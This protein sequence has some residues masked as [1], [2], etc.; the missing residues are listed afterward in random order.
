M[1]GIA[2]IFA[3]AGAPIEP[4]MIQAMIATLGHRGPDEQGTWID[5][6]IGLASSRL[7]IIDLAGSHQPMHDKQAGGHLAFN[8]EIFNYREVRATTPYGYRTDGDTETL[9]AS[10]VQRGPVATVRE[11]VGQFAFGY[12]DSIGQSL[13]LAR[14][15]LGVLPLYYCQ[16]PGAVLFAS[17]IKAL[18]AARPTV[19][20]DQ[21]SITE[22]LVTRAVRAPHTLLAGIR[23]VSSAHLLTITADG[24]VSESRYWSPPQ[25]HDLWTDSS[26]TL[27]LDEALNKAVDRAL[28]ADVPVGSYLSGGLDSSLIATLASRRTQGQR[29][30]TFSAGF[31]GASKG[32]DELPYAEQVAASIGSEHHIVRIAPEAFEVEWSRLS[33]FRDGPLSEPADVAVAALA[34]LARQQVR[35][36]LSG[37]GADELFAGYPKHRFDALARFGQHVPE[38]WRQGLADT[39]ASR[40]PDSARRAQVMVRAAGASSELERFS[41]WFAPFTLAE[42]QQTYRMDDARIERV[43]DRQRTLFSDVPAQQ[44]TRLGRLLAYDLLTWL[45]DNLLERG[46]R[47]TMSASVELRPPFLDHELVELAFSLP[48]RYKLRGRTGKWLV[49]QVAARYLSPT[50]IN[51]RKAGFPVPLASWFR[52]DWKDLARDNLLSADSI[53]VDLLGRD[54]VAGLLDT[55]ER[56]AADQSSKL[57]TLL[58]LDRWYRTLAAG[59]ATHG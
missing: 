9:L 8:G 31:I 43:R 24:R 52:G 4:D 17:E 44:P 58:S 32:Q 49:K 36:V 1:C 22:Y 55:H 53:S 34:Q 39:A 6:N 59:V 5:G 28:V 19:E 20:L 18:L 27:A 15:R 26:A 45:P 46:D 38:R 42:L 35:V 37:E 3:Y 29:L 40:L 47:M 41:A 57:W 30:H 33:S 10:L 16:V 25:P 12:F 56:R 50:I 13:T 51:R 11:L 48:D 23:K 2:G 21:D 7:A 54:D 14:D